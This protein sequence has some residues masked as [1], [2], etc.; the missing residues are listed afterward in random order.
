MRS[1]LPP[2]IELTTYTNDLDF[3]P[4]LGIVKTDARGPN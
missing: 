2:T 4:A 1:N 3:V